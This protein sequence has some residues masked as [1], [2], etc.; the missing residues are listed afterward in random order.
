MEK[1]NMFGNSHFVHSIICP[2]GMTFKANGHCSSQASQL[3]VI[4]LL[5]FY[6]SS[7]HSTFP[8]DEY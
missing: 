5:L 8:N 3:G 4:D 7:I 2:A 1:D 6:S